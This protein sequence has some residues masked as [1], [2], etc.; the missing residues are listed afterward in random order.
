MSLAAM[1]SSAARSG[2]KQSEIGMASDVLPVRPCSGTAAPC[3]RPEAEP[4]RCRGAE[5]QAA[6]CSSMSMRSLSLAFRKMPCH[7]VSIAGDEKTDPGLA[8][9]LGEV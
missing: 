2:A 5:G 4:I 8:P 6:R 9:C 3:S 1:F 7:I